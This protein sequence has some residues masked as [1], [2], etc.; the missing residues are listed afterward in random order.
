MTPHQQ[1]QPKPLHPI[2]S[3][4][5]TDPLAYVEGGEEGGDALPMKVSTEVS[6]TR[7]GAYRIYVSYC[8]HLPESFSVL[9]VR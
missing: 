3:L 9:S 2:Q 1:K 8:L 7:A 4:D 6:R 5:E